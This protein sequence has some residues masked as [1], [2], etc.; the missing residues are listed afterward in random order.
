MK[1]IL[2]AGFE[3]FGQD[4]INPA[5]EAVKL[6]DGKQLNGGIIVSCEVPVVRYKAVNVVM[7]AVKKHQPDIVIT[8][9][10][11]AGRAEITPERIAIN[12]DDY[13][14]PDNEGNKVIDEAIVAIGP[15]AYFSTLPIKAMV[16]ALQLKNIPAQVSN[17]A[18]TFVC[19]HIFY[20]VQ[21]YLVDTNITHGFVHI[22]LLPE[23]TKDSNQ[24]SMPLMMI[25]EGLAVLAQAALDNKQD[26]IIGGGTIC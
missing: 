25:V 14:I 10:Q 17:S 4:T 26:K 18:G 12:I 9:G 21:H 23:Q 22:P 16:E 5:L 1:K 20:G 11:A 6:L 2:M 15:A 13:R 7:E 24:P 8:I 3:P 19:N